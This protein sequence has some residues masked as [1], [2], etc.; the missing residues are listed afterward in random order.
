MN[1]KDT[2]RKKIRR[3]DDINCGK[4]CDILSGNVVC[5]EM[6]VCFRKRILQSPETFKNGI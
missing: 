1:L 5:Q 6:E 2:E 3:L 4:M